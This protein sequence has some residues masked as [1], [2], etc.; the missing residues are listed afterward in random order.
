[1]VTIGEYRLKVPR[2]PSENAMYTIHVN[3]TAEQK[4]VVVLS[5]GSVISGYKIVENEEYCYNSMIAKDIYE[6]I[7]KGLAGCTAKN[8]SAA[9]F[10]LGTVAVHSFT[11]ASA[12]YQ[13]LK[14]QNELAGIEMTHVKN[15]PKAKREEDDRPEFEVY[16]VLSYTQNQSFDWPLPYIKIT[17]E[18]EFGEETK[19]E[20][21]IKVRS[22]EEI[23]L[24]K[25]ISWLLKKNYYIIND[26]VVA[27]QIFQL[28][29]NW[30]EAIVFDTETTG[31]R[32]NMFSKINSKEKAFLDDYNSKRPVDEQIRSDKL[33]GII[34]CVEENVSYYF[35]CFNRKFTNIYENKDSEMRKKLIQRFKSDYTIGKYRNEDTDMARYWRNTPEDEITSDCILMERVRDILTKGHMAAH[36]GAFDWKVAYCY[37]IDLNLKDDTII[38]HQLMY[39]FRSTTKN[40]GESSKLKDLARLELGIDQLDLEDFFVGYKEDDSG[41]VNAKGVKKAKKSTKKKKMD[42]D[43]SYMD[44]AGSKAYAPADGDMTLCLLH[45]YK[46][47][48]LENHKEMEYLYNVELIVSCAV[49]YMEFYGHRI[50]ENKIERIRDSYIRQS[51]V[52]E[53]KIRQMAKLSAPDEDFDF[54]TLDVIEEDIKGLDKE[55]DELKEE[56]EKAGGVLDDVRQRKL[57]ALEEER[58]EYFTRREQQEA[59]CRQTIA[60]SENQF[61][62][63][64]PAQVAELFYDKME[65]PP[66]DGVRT[67]AKKPLKSLLKMKDEN[68]KTKYPI[69]EL[70]SDWKKVDT[71][72]TK[73]FDNLQY[74]MYPGGFIFSHYGQISTATGRMTC[75]K[76]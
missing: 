57:T 37:D 58:K 51:L 15:P 41:T 1:M 65:I 30:K 4:E 12:N 67:V 60:E 69:V 16:M 50:D 52:L 76:P 14:Y 19:P 21:K 31:L 29:E 17:L 32:I 42:I 59:K 55:I 73:F 53:H 64:S 46:K 48:L 10:E 20:D 28:L 39:K 72:L 7:R 3:Y 62:L 70:Y 27:E 35:P 24:K 6:Y 25:D 68:G 33:V 23:S 44:Y 13:V 40:S 18:E 61:N 9:P 47:D 43:F 54:R 38:L 66:V 49:G 36:N 56:K 26:D 5:A 22:L 63:A 34:L 11:K 75:N 74:F 2:N 71:L 45:K 8:A